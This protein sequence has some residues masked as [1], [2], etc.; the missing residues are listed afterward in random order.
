MHDGVGRDTTRRR[1]TAA[2]LPAVLVGWLML[3]SASALATQSNSHA[4]GHTTKTQSS[5]ASSNSDHSQGNAGTSGD[6]NSPQPQS[7][8]D[9]NSGGAN[10]QCPGGTYCST[11]DG[12]PS[13]N[14]NG[15]GQAK[16]KPCAG[17]V[18][19]ADNKNPPGQEKNDPM[20]TFPNNGYECDHNNGIGKSNPA[21]TGCQS[22]STP[23]P[24]DSTTEDCGTPPPCD[25]AT[26]DCGT[27]PPCDEATQD[28][29]SPP[30]CDEATEDC[31]SPPPTA[32]V[33][34]AANNFCSNV[35]GEHHSKTPQTTPTPSVLG[36]KLT[37]TPSVA[38][39]GAL[40]FTGLPLV[41]LVA[42]GLLTMAAG[43]LLTAA[44]IR[45]RREA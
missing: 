25:E 16:G 15:G 43:V 6:P 34:T 33:P 14:G 23:P 24:C 3:G 2:L 22:S 37:R 30:P 21:H 45:R 1:R 40:P 13:L 20:G 32:C 4:K 10:G 19:K 38:P 5:T 12:S 9:Q 31:S 18:G 28:C 36:E 27:P 41:G 17:C 7:K 11:R 39:T 35:E 26:Q 44:T 8:A 42:A 29:G